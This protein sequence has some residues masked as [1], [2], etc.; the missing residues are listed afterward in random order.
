MKI[1]NLQLDRLRERLIERKIHLEL[2]DEVLNWILIK[3]YDPIYGARP[4]KRDI[5]KEIGTK[6]AKFIL[7]GNSKEGDT[8]KVQFKDSDLVLS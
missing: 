5:E 4:I 8:I 3:G 2:N 6:I 1:V 7:K